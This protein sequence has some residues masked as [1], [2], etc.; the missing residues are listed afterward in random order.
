MGSFDIPEISAR[1]ASERLKADP[2]VRLIDVR[3]DEEFSIARI[4]GAI[5]VNQEKQLE[6]MMRWPKET[7]LIVH[8]HHGMRSMQA[9][10]FFLNRGFTNVVNLAGGIDAWSADVDP[11]VPRY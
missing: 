3:T 8:C 7:P 9:A 10:G 2:A 1:E 6:E 5:L 11:T 4:P